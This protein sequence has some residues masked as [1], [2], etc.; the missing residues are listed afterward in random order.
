MNKKL[1]L[2]IDDELI[3]FAHNYSKQTGQSISSIVEKYF[4]K[5]KENKQVDKLSKSTKELY[6]ILSDKPLSD[7]KDFR[8]GKIECL[9]A[10]E[11]VALIEG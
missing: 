4:E 6:G 5:L 11:A 8:K 1:T 10:L 2:N 9:S 7:I 3:E